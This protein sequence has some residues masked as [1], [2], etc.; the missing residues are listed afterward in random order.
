L[1]ENRILTYPISIWRPSS[2]WRHW[3]FV[4]IFGTRKTESLSYCMV[5]FSWSCV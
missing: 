1:V 4:A 5:L 2:G 3:N